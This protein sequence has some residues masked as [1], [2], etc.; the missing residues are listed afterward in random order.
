MPLKK[1]PYILAVGK[2]YA[3]A[4]L[5]VIRVHGFLGWCLQQLVELRYLLF[6]LP[7][8]KAIQTWLRGEK[9][10]MSND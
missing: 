5:L 9:Y 7:T 10:F 6:I 2:K 4:D 3:I 1:Y 8:K